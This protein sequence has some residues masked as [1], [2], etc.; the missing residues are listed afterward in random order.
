MSQIALVFVGLL[1]ASILPW[2]YS[3]SISLDQH[4]QSGLSH[5]ERLA[6]RCFIDDF[7]LW[8]QRNDELLSWLQIAHL[9]KLPIHDGSLIQ[10][11]LNQYRLQHQCL[12]FHEHLTLSLGPG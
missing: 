10:E 1:I 11:E 3:E 5:Y 4:S 8:L 2:V 12:R 7:P 6:K 9:L